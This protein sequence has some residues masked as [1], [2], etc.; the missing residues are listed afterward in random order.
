MNTTIRSAVA[1]INSQNP[2]LVSQGFEAAVTCT[3]TS[4]R[5]FSAQSLPARKAV[6][7]GDGGR[8]LA[9]PT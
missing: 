6:I 4:Q 3:N 8:S 2:N 1:Q 7:C 5:M 9:L